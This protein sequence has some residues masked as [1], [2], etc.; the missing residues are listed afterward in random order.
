MSESPAAGK[1]APG[2]LLVGGFEVR[3]T[4]LPDPKLLG[5]SFDVAVAKLQNRYGMAAALF[6]V[7]MIRI[8]SSNCVPTCK[9]AVRRYDGILE[10]RQRHFAD[11]LRQTLHSKINSSEPI[12]PPFQEQVAQ[13]VIVNPCVL[14]AIDGSP[15]SIYHVGTAQTK[16]QVHDDQLQRRDLFTA[17]YELYGAGLEHLRDSFWIDVF[18]GLEIHQGV[19][20]ATN[21]FQDT[22][23]QRHPEGF[24]SA[25]RAQLFPPATVED[26]T[27]AAALDVDCQM[28]LT[29][30]ALRTP[31]MER[32]AH[33]RIPTGKL[34]G[35]Y[36]KLMQF[37]GAHIAC[38]LLLTN[39]KD[40]V[41]WLAPF[42]TNNVSQLSRTRNT[43]IYV[44][45]CLVQTMLAMCIAYSGNK[46]VEYLTRDAKDA[47]SSEK[48]LT[49]LAG[50]MLALY[51]IKL[52]YEWWTESEEENDEKDEEESC[53]V[54]CVKCTSLPGNVPS[55]LQPRRYAKVSPETD[56]EDGELTP[57]WQE[58]KHNDSSNEIEI[59]S[60]APSQKEPLAAEAV[61]AE[62]AQTQ[63]LFVIAFIGSLDDLTLF[64]PM[65][66]GKGF[67]FIQ[68]IIGALT[69]SGLIVSI[70]L[71]VG[72]CQPVA[73]CI[74]KVPLFAIVVGFATL[75]LAKSFT[76][77]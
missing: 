25:S 4:Q 27:M 50:S 39:A 13:L 16:A 62:T 71:F 61:W 54:K 29:S 49:V 48:I 64:V 23:V 22:R 42:L 9:E 14:V 15:V 19:D 40:D 68:L 59:Q 26:A 10:W 53:I 6:K 65:L 1:P 75:L 2:Y 11:D 7:F 18:N 33:E 56:V 36:A 24:D 43:A 46:I 66:V 55:Y 31:A 74:S 58:H 17:E 20:C 21:S 77:T 34:Q 44:S 35:P 60:K 69:A 3:Q 72:L 28:E 38:H 73:D 47:W 51:S 70:C 57:M 12:L 52:L 5:P 76:M 8:C 41:V 37:D 45:V 30:I 63:T 32:P 67:D